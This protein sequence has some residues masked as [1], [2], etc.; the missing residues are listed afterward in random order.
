MAPALVFPVL[1]L[2]PI[3]HITFLVR[4]GIY[5]QA[6][7]AGEP[8]S[9]RKSPESPPQSVYAGANAHKRL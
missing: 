6:L 3:S 7:R 1:V 4:F 8:L 9:L 2:N 5:P